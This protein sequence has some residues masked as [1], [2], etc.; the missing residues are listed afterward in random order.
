[1]RLRIHR[2]EGT[3][4]WESSVP[5]FRIGRA[6]TCALRFEGESAKYA[7]WE[8]A[9]FSTDDQG[10]TYV[11][12]MESKNGTY[13][14]GA[15]I[16]APTPLRVGSV[17]QIGTKGPKLDVLD[18]SR[19]P[20]QPAIAKSATAWQPRWLIVGSAAAVLLLVGFLFLRKGD[21]P[22]PKAIAQDPSNDDH[23]DQPQD[24]A[25]QEAALRDKLQENEPAAPPI[26][27]PI[28]PP[29]VKSP[30][31]AVA[32]DARL[33]S[34]RLITVE[35]PETQTK[36]PF[37]GAVVVGPHALLTT[38]NVAIELTKLRNRGWSIKVGRDSQDEGV[39]IEQIRVHALYQETEPDKQPY[40]DLALLSVNERLTGTTRQATH[41]ELG[42]LKQGAQ[43]KCV[44]VNHSGDS[45]DRFEEL[46][47][48]VYDAHVTNVS[49]LSPDPGAPR[50]LSLHGEFGENPSGS[51][52]FDDRGHLVALY[53]DAAPLADGK[54]DRDNHYA[55]MVQ[56]GLIKL[57][58][59]QAENQY[60][61]APT[62]ATD[63]SNTKESEK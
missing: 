49:N 40:F 7:G 17:V 27:Q 36:R 5:I 41:E 9:E 45:F 54:P 50:V 51:P 26:K 16:S 22:Q 31:P 2:P 42:A 63:V 55:A 47:P 44:A 53:C 56:P 23:Q 48:E 11:T 46:R 10:G 60:W 21:A 8:H 37:A 52:I 12:D 6:D 30:A 61:V 19:A 38:A 3:S 1:M 15:R 43:L 34:F 58:I 35:D 62:V 33:E 25:N 59:A 18:L 57:G 4:E 14:N 24:E 32:K 20:A 13:V 39:P 29:E 28:S